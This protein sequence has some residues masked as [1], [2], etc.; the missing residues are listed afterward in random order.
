MEFISVHN[1]CE[2]LNKA[3]SLVFG[4]KK[5]VKFCRSLP[6][7]NYT[8]VVV[9]DVIDLYYDSESAKPDAYIMIIID[10]EGQVTVSVRRLSD[11]Y[12]V[13]QQIGTEIQETLTD[14]MHKL[15]NVVQGGK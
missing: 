12:E 13:A 1:R 6:V 3:Y 4:D 5:S 11:S 9:G 10:Y 14:E 2:V 8:G 15:F 7:V